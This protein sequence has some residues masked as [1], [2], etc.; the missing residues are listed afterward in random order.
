MERF[1]LPTSRWALPFVALLA[2]RGGDV[3]VDAD[4][5]HV[6]LGLL[7]RADVPLD[8]VARISRMQWPW[9]GGVG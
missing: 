5:V 6:R 8:A 3:V 7:G 9:W 2:P 4:G 1:P